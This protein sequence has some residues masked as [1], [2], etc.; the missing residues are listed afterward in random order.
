MDG[1]DI[2]HA[3]RSHQPVC[4]T[5]QVVATADDRG[6]VSIFKYPS[7]VDKP[8]KAVIGHGHSSHVTKCRFNA[9]DTYLF[10]VGG[11][12]TTV[13]QWRIRKA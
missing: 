7:P 1:S 6:K 9:T 12:D 3:D 10:S 11:N 4:S 13:M 5:G 8:A 2:N